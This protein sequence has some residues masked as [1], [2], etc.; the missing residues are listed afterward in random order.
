MA[1]ETVLSKPNLYSYNSYRSFLKDYYQYEKAKGGSRFS[2]RILSSRADLGSPNYFKLVMEGKRNLSSKMIPRFAKALKL[3]SQQTLFFET[4]VHFNQAASAAQKDAY[5]KN[6]LKFREY[7]AAASL[8]AKQYQY[9]SHWYY[10]AIREMAALKGFR[11]NP[12][13][14]ASSLHPPISEKQAKEA[15]AVLFALGLLQRD[16][17]GKA[18]QTDSHLKT[19]ETVTALSVYNFHREMIQKGLSALDE[20]SKDRE[21]SSITLALPKQE[22]PALKKK[23]YQFLYDLQAWLQGLA[24][25][26]DAVYQLNFQLFGLTKEKSRKETP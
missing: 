9:L 4:L 24:E 10:V 19:D 1:K 23:I 2:F 17:N 25:E 18:Q 13:W 12:K 15:L 26:S 5:F 6:L 7:R 11:E 21:I 8:H 14:I 3:E 16:K 20:K 22:L